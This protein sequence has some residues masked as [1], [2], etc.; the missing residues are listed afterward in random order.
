MNP[1]EL[2]AHADFVHALAR[3]L[4][5]DPNT[6]DDIAQQ[7][8]VA[9]LEHP[10]MEMGS[11]TAWFSKVVRNF[12]RLAYRSEQRTRNRE[13]KAAR[14]ESRPSSEEIVEKMETLR[15]LIDAVDRKSVV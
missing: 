11:R 4:V 9:A 6:A 10:P 8:W 5:F 7:T 12:T 1:E 2:L 3:S 15:L 13:A 14:A